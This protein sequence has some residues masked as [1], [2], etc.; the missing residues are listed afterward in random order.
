M[1]AARAKQQLINAFTKGMNF[2]NGKPKDLKE[3][4]PDQI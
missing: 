4:N 3:E 2:N 1:Q